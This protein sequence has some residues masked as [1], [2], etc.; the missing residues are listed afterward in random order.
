MRVVSRRSEGVERRSVLFDMGTNIVPWQYIVQWLFLMDVHFVTRAGADKS[1][2]MYI[3]GTT[4][5]FVAPA[6][7]EVQIKFLGPS[8]LRDFIQGAAEAD[9][10]NMTQWLIVASLEKAERQGLKPPEKR[11]AGK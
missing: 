6:D 7:D 10:R 1:C 5:F 4:F 8:W 9:H 11:K 3:R 2:S